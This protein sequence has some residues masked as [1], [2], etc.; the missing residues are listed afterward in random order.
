MVY[1][2]TITQELHEDFWQNYKAVVDKYKKL[3]TIKGLSKAFLIE[4]TIEET[5]PKKWPISFQTAYR[6]ICKKLYN[7]VGN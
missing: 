4:K 1:D 7:G 5:K 2:N 3:G 6:L